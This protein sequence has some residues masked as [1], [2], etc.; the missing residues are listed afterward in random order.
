MKYFGLLAFIATVTRGHDSISCMSEGPLL[1]GLYLNFNVERTDLDFVDQV[2][3]DQLNTAH[4][5]T[6]VMVCADRAQDYIR[7]IQISYGKFFS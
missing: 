1:G 7:G 2:Y 4:V 5:L 3:T 6:G